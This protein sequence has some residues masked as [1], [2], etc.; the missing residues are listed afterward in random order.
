MHDAGA[1]CEDN[2]KSRFKSGGCSTLVLIVTQ[3]VHSL[4]GGHHGS[5]GGGKASASGTLS[6]FWHSGIPASDCEHVSDGGSV[7]VALLR[8]V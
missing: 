3:L 7:G 2:R 1:E 6:G 5:P 4:G 8:E